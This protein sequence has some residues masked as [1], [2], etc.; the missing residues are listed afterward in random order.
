MLAEYCHLRA[1]S[2]SK[3]LSEGRWLPPVEVYVSGQLCAPFWTEEQRSRA[4]GDSM[5]CHTSGGK[6]GAA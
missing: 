3:V 5:S 6:F 1:S 4:A 2:E